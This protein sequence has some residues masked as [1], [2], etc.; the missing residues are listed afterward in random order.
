MILLDKLIFVEF[1][2]RR[3]FFI[4][5][6]WMINSRLRWAEHLECI[7]ENRITRSF[8][9]CEF[10]GKKPIRRPRSRWENNIKMGVGKIRTGSLN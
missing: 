8:L 2:D 10:A 7:G 9:V 6:V 3:M 4:V 1:F 5:F